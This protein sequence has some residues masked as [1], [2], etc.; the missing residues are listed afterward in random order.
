MCRTKCILQSIEEYYGVVVPD[1][2]I[3]CNKL[4]PYY[5]GELYKVVRRDVLI[6]RIESDIFDEGSV[7]LGT[8]STKILS[9]KGSIWA[10]KA[11]E[12]KAV[13]THVLTIMM[14]VNN[15]IC[16]HWSSASVSKDTT[17]NDSIRT[18]KDLHCSFKKRP[19]GATIR[20]NHRDD[21]CWLQIPHV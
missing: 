20:M 3:K 18:K 9:Y 11:K 1:P 10:N 21:A 2:P 6:D 5:R 14:W 17:T 12:V 7:T 15:I 13:D 4:C 16:I 8:F 19:A